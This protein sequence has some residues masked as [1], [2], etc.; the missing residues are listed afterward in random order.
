M[1]ALVCVFVD[2]QLLNCLNEA[3]LL[4]SRHNLNGHA[5]Q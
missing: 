1:H 4:I 5:I 2:K 3:H